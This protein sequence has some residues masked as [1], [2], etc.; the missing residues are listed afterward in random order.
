MQLTERDKVIIRAVY[1]YRILKQDQVQALF[2]GPKLSHKAAT[3]RRLVKLFDHGYLSRFFLPTKGGL[4]SSPILYGLD[5]RG[6]ELLRAEFGIEELSWYPSYRELK[7]DFLEHSLAIA[8]FRVAVTLACDKLGYTLLAW[9]NEGELK[10]DYDRA[11]VRGKGRQRLVAVIPDGYFVI[12]TPFGHAHFFLE[13]DRGTMTTARFRTKV[14]AY[15]AY[16]RAGMYQKRYNTTSLRILTVTLGAGRL[17]NL[18]RVTADVGNT[19]WFWFGVL[20][21]LTAETVLNRTVWEVPGK[22]GI[23]PLIEGNR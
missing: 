9:K 4:M 5:K 16:F 13:L 22:P 11:E 19:S 15:I 14:E 1:Q 18:K 6:T 2:F 23:L 21:N 7:D 10:A 17:A 8:E 3:Q 20:A 12:Q